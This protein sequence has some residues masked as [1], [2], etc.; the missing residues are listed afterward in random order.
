M[1]S[2]PL[3][4]STDLASATPDTLALLD[5]RDVIALDQDPLAAPAR[6][7]RDDGT[8]IVLRRALADGG[9]ALAVVNLGDQPQHVTDLPATTA[10]DLWTGHDIDARSLTLA[11]HATA[12]L[13]LPPSS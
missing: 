12:L 9:T 5:N 3:M 2:A 13:R 7:L 11:P 8:V 6:V 1:L 4:I 10:R